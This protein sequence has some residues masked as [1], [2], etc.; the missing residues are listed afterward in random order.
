MKSVNRNGSRSKNRL[1]TISMVAQTSVPS[2]TGIYSWAQPCPPH[3]PAIESQR[4]PASTL[5]GIPTALQNEMNK[6]ALPNIIFVVLLISLLSVSCGSKDQAGD[7][8]AIGTKQE[9]ESPSS[10]QIIQTDLPLVQLGDVYRSPEGGYEF[11]VVPDY[12]LEEFAGIISMQ[13]PDADPETGPL[14]MLVGGL[15]EETK[16]TEQLLED[17]R[18]GLGQEGEIRDREQ[19]TIGGIPGLMVNFDAS[20][21]G[22]PTAGRAVFVAVTP[23]QV[24]SLFSFAPSEL[25]GGE[26]SDIFDALI[27][28][29]NFFEPELDT[30][31]EPEIPEAVVSDDAARGELIRQ[32]ASSAVASSEYSNPD[33]AATQATGA[34]S[35][36]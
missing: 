30:A 28:S 22:E 14:F 32:W 8:Q 5:A 4:P 15:N 11:R 13:A 31:G 10:E 29:L 9:V 27:A 33:Y 35:S 20:V 16:T 7:D 23:T 3:S 17:F 25:S 24:F 19:I 1:L 34:G 6:N 26:L 12:L 2:S 18:Q 36:H 21:E